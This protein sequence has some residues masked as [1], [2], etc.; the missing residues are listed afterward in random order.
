[1]SIKC[2]SIANKSLDSGANGANFSSNG[3][4][5]I[6]VLDGNSSLAIAIASSSFLNYIENP[7][8]RG[9]DHARNVQI[10]LHMIISEDIKL[11]QILNETITHTT[12]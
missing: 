12:A 4:F 11:V 3:K 10:E 5:S 7:E 9:N 8:G 1:M 6:N 2:D